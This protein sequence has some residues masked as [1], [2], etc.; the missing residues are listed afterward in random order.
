MKNNPKSCK[1]IL[2]FIIVMM[3]INNSYTVN[4]FNVS[5]NGFNINGSTYIDDIS[6]S[7]T[8]SK[9]KDSEEDDLKYN[10][11]ICNYTDTIIYPEQFDVILKTSKGND[12]KLLME[13]NGKCEIKWLGD[14]DKLILRLDGE[15]SE[16]NINIEEVIIQYNKDGK[17]LKNRL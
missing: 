11:L 4:F 3:L 2:S 13:E 17:I 14:F 7:V 9:V 6:T 12:I 5:N 15:Y 8:I 10:L 1:I 16:E